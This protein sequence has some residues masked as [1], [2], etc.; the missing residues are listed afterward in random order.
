MALLTTRQMVPPGPMLQKHHIATNHRSRGWGV[1]QLSYPYIHMPTGWELGTQLG[2]AR[3]LSQ[4]IAPNCETLGDTVTLAC[5]QQSRNPELE[6]GA[7]PPIPRA[8]LTI[9]SQTPGSLS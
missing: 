2:H 7:V 8:H 4:A 6:C 9:Y 1:Q 3:T 5:T